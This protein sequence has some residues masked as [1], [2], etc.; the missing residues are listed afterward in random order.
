MRATSTL[1][2]LMLLACA[3][4]ACRSDCDRY[5]ARKNRS[6]ELCR[7]CTKNYCSRQ[8]AAAEKTTEAARADKACA[9]GCEPQERLDC[10]CMSRCLNTPA[11]KAAVD[12]T[13]ACVVSSCSSECR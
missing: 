6:S 4:A 13:Y 5:A 9:E 10:A 12:N 1:F 8:A 2:A 11:V 3:T 7:A